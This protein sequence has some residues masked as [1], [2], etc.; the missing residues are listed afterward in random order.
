MQLVLEEGG[1]C[2][3]NASNPRKLVGYVLL[4]LLP[5]FFYRRIYCS[6]AAAAGVDLTSFFCKPFELK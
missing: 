3:S 2:S 5:V 6:V 4:L 1:R